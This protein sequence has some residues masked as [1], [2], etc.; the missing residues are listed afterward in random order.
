MFRASRTGWIV[1]AALALAIAAPPAP[2]QP[3]SPVTMHPGLTVNFSVYGG[4]NS[5]GE[6]IG[7]YDFINQIT[8][9]SGGGYRYDYW[10]TGPAVNSGSQ[11]V[12]PEDKKS[13]T[14]LREF[15]PSG[16]MTA[17]G[18]ISCLGVS[19]A[20]YA[21]LKAGKETPF[22]FDGPDSPQTL[23]KIGEEDLTTLV[24]EH[25]TTLHTIKAQGKT[26]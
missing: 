15:W 16:D 9:I 21:D 20:T 22:T 26:G 1:A 8:E 13:G 6:L 12:S 10:F 23:K 2:A 11:T 3:A 19:D 7:D 17:K 14:I 4:L 25:Q 5:N 18:Y 24:N